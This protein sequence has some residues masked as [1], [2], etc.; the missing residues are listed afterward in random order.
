MNSITQR[1][2][3]E[4]QANPQVLGV[5]LFGSWA[6]GNNR[7]DSDVDLLVIVQ[8]GFK[9]T[10]EY[11]EGQAFEMIYITEQ[12]AIEYWQSHPNDAVELWKVAKILF[13]REGTIARLQQVGNEI[14]ERGKIP[15]TADQYAHYK[16]DV[17]DQLRAIE[18]LAKSDP[19]T[20]R[21]LLS[22]KVSQLSELFF[23]IR[24]LW[25]PPP[26]QRLAIIKDLNPKLYDLIARY[27][28]EQILLEQMNIVKSMVALVFD[29]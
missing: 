11:R 7:P 23:D 29:R 2:I 24:Q 28:E 22:V 4:L 10:V 27:Y 20:A 16:F 21:M 18:E 14:R 9:R 12:E 19:T 8:D 17:H 3:E 6:R 25:T 26:K 13:D 5:I 15:P 1:F